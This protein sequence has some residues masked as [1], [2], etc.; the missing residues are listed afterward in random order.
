VLRGLTELDDTRSA[1]AVLQTVGL[2]A[3]LVL[4]GAIWW[5]PWVVA[6]A[7][8]LIATQQHAM[9]RAGA[10]RRALPPV[11]QSCAE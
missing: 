6:P 5:T 1:L 3:A 8:L 9:F 10:R 7:V 4:V 11:L 2:L